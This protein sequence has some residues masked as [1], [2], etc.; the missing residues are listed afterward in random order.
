LKLKNFKPIGEKGLDL[1]LKPLTLL[2]GRNGSGK[3]SVLEAM[4]LLS[5]NVGQSEFRLTGELVQFLSYYEVEHK[6][7]PGRWITWEI[8]SHERGVRYEHK[9]D[10]GEGRETVIKEGRDIVQFGLEGDRRRPYTLWAQLPG[11]SGKV[12]VGNMLTILDGGKYRGG[13]ISSLLDD[14][15]LETPKGKAE[16]AHDF[17]ERPRQER[18][19][20][21]ERT[22]DI[23]DELAPQIKE[24]LYFLSSH[25]GQISRQESTAVVARWVGVSGQFLLPLLSL[26]QS[27]SIPEYEAAWSKIQEWATEFGLLKLKAGLRAANL[28]RADF[29]DSELKTT[30]NLAFAGY[31]SRQIMPVIA[32]LFWAQPGS[33]IMIE[34]PEISLHPEAQVKLGEL[35]AEAVQENKQ[36]IATTHSHFLLLAKIGRAHV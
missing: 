34:E 31:G 7:D 3:S 11:K 17:R 6:H 33:I 22:L 10:S 18:I 29:L 32:Q 35:F 28:V 8:Q 23:V 24:R 2:V 1:G 30:I 27:S 14:A 5:A 13:I 21:L 25:R 20:Q 4:S 15:I 12:H 26:I 19:S 9:P 16:I 36:I